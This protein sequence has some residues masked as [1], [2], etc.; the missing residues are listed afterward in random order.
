MNKNLILLTISQVFGFSNAAITVF[1]GGIIGSQITSVKL[2]S[3]LPV[4]LSVVGTA[5]FTFFAAKIMSK[6]KKL[7]LSTGYD[8]YLT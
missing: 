7:C 5:I 3:T 1:L 2:L 4:A 8:P 6:I